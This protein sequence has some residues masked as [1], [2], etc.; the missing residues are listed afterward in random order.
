MCCFLYSG[1]HSGAVGAAG[2][3]P[4]GPEEAQPARGGTCAAD[5]HLLAFSRYCTSDSVEH[6]E[7]YHEFYMSDR[8]C[9]FFSNR[10]YIHYGFHCKRST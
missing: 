9:L 3:V 2:E 4:G 10:E 5:G 6:V 7:G 1:P 8:V